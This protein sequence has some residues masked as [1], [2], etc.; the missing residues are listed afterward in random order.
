MKFF[1]SIFVIAVI[2][3]I[4][5]FRLSKVG[6]K[7]K[8]TKIIHQKA[9]IV[10]TL[11]ALFLL[12]LLTL[13]MYSSEGAP[14]TQCTTSHTTS[15]TPPA[16]LK[17]AADFFM[18]GN[19]DYDI[20]NC[21]K[22]ITDYTESIKLDPKNSQ[23][24]NNR[25]Y[26]YMRL[27]DYKSALPD[28]DKAISLNPNYINALMNR[29]DIHNYYYAIDRNVAI[30]DYEKVITLGGTKGTSVCGHLFLAEHKGWNLG[31][32]LAIPSAYFRCR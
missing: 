20:G 11:L 22:A 12:T 17:T 8:K 16:S 31:T 32:L 7:S 29:G 13:A 24:Y 30:T 10:S 2:V 26:T 5:Y 15:T 28:L 3:I 4:V 6:G 23:T 1:V 19:Y 25:A 27:R 9:V 21:T 14:D 18:Q